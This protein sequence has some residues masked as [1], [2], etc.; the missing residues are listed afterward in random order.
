MS[1]NIDIKGL[2]SKQETPI[3]DLKELFD[4]VKKFK[5]I[6]LRKLII[7]NMILLSQT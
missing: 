7:V 1:N 3:P 2:W 4:K 6:N 5:K